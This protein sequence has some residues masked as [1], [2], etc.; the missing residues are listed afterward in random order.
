[1]TRGERFVQDVLR[2]KA[3]LRARW[4]VGLPAA[5]VA[6]LGLAG[7][8]MRRRIFSPGTYLHARRVGA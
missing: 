5:L 6:L 1:M 8:M 2:G 3:R 7:M 4:I